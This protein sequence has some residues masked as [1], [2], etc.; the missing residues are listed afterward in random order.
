MTAKRKGCEAAQWRGSPIAVIARCWPG[1]L[2]A[3]VER[4]KAQPRL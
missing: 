2:G 3:N 1:R 4:R